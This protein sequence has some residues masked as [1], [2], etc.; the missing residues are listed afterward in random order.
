MTSGQKGRQSYQEKKMKKKR[1]NLNKKQ[2]EKIKTH[3]RRMTEKVKKEDVIRLAKTFEE[4]FK[5]AKDKLKDHPKFGVFIRQCEL[6]YDIIRDWVKGEYDP[7]WQVI[8]AI[9]AALLYVI[10]PVDIIPDFIP[11]IGYIDDLFVVALCIKLIRGELRRYCEIKGIDKS[12][13]ALD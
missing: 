2:K 5:K 4:K 6:L 12:L 10:N 7:P 3:F 1:D 13:Y 9:T 11:V 8:G